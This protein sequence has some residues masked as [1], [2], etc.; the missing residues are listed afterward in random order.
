M[1]KVLAWVWRV[2]AWAWF[3]FALGGGLVGLGGFLP[4]D[5]YGQS[6]ALQV[7]SVAM[8]LLPAVVAER[9][10]ISALADKVEDGIAIQESLI[11]EAVDSAVETGHLIRL[12]TAEE[13]DE[14]GPVERADKATPGEGVSR[15]L[16]EKLHSLKTFVQL[17]KALL[18][19]GWE[20]RLR[21]HHKVYDRGGQRIVIPLTPARPEL[22]LRRILRV[23][24][25]MGYVPKGNP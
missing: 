14:A 24:D 22:T 7:G 6:A 25:G 11:Q 5:S 20:L 15:D 16:S 9:A 4:A 1:K 13:R 8:L 2:P 3:V 23:L 18:R 10:I 17:E 19:D 21:G 12:G